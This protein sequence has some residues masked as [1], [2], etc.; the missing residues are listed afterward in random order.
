MTDDMD[1]VRRDDEFLEALIGGRAPDGL[2]V[3]EQRLAALLHGW[4]TELLAAPLPEHPTLV[5]VEVAIAA[6]EAVRAEA[7]RAETQ[8]GAVRHL[9]LLAGAA[10]ITAVAAAG[11]MVLSENS[12]PGDPLW[13]VKKVV[14]AQAAQQTQATVDV[15][16]SLERAEAAIASGD[17]VAARE[18][19]DE[20]ERDL[21]PVDDTATRDHM[22]AWIQRLRTDDQLTS[23]PAR[24][25]VPSDSTTLTPTTLPTDV[26]DEEPSPTVTVTVPPLDPTTP[27]ETPVPTPPSTT[28]STPPTTE[29]SVIQPSATT[30]S[31]SLP[32]S[33][34]LSEI[35][36][37]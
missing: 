28:P 17:I 26:T 16:D 24:P 20:A 14:F 15:Q 6:E 34:S 5:D 33:T 27:T 11:L 18:L 9:R 31:S 1:A 25:A 35:R 23:S 22:E 12:Q 19:I 36:V 13:N 4:R 2:D 29:P 30:S 10:A 7:E 8:R 32:T 3:G 37:S 21:K